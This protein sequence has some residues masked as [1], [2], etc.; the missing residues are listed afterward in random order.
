MKD[1]KLILLASL[2]FVGCDMRPVPD[3]IRNGKGYRVETV[4]T[5]DSTYTDLVYGPTFGPTFGNFSYGSMKMG[6]HAKTKHKCLE[7]RTDTFELKDFKV[8][9]EK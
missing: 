3:F 2:L 7:H 5:R 8:V 4:C 6:L 1:I 9:H